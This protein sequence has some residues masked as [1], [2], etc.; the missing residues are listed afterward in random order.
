MDEGRGRR[1]QRE[2]GKKAREGEEDRDG[3]MERVERETEDSGER[4]MNSLN[5]PKLQSQ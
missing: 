5:E 1:R 2:V 4:I 3:E